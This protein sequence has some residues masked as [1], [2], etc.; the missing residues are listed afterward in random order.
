M[1]LLRSS[2]RVTCAA[3]GK[4]GGDLLA[5]A[6]MEIEPDI[7]RH[8]V[9][10]VRRAGRVGLAGSVTAGSGSMSTITAS[11]ASFAC[12]DGLG[13]DRGDRLADMADLVGRQ[14]VPDGL[15]IGVPS[16]LFMTCRAGNGPM[17]PAAR[18]AAV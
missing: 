10:K 17:P 12:G 4:G 11:A 8:V 16:R 14:R 7:A 13:D 2:S 18:S 1:R 6:E 15:S 9:V 5:V 3:R